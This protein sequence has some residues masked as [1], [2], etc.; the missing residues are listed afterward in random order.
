MSSQNHIWSLP[1]YLG[2]NMSHIIG[3]EM[4]LRRPIF[5]LAGISLTFLLFVSQGRLAPL[6]RPSTY[7]ASAGISRGSGLLDDIHNSTLGV[8]AFPI[9]RVEGY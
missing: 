7:F 9:R 8:R 3:P 2:R 5:V 6:G 1:Q 4:L